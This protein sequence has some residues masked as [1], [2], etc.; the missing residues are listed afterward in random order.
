VQQTCRASQLQESR[1]ES[2]LQKTHLFCSRVRIGR[3]RSFKFDAFGTNRKHICDFL[4]VR[5][6]TWSCLAPFRK[7]G[8][9]LAEKC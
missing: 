5:H 6:I 8:D 4:L 3:L 1:Y 7:Y 2:W 9:L